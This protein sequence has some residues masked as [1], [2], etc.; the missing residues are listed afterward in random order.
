MVAFLDDDIIPAPGWVQALVDDVRP[1]DQKVFHMGYCPHA[2]SSI[3]TYLDRRNA[4]WYE[5]RIR[6]ISR[7][8]YEPRWQDFFCGN[9]AASRQELLELGGFDARFRI[10]EDDELGF[11]AFKNGWRI[12]FV[13]NA[14]A[15]HHFHR[16]HRAYG[17]QAF[18]AGRFDGLLVRLHPEMTPF[19]RIGTR[20]AAWKRAPG[21]I[22]K[23][24][25]VNSRRSVE[26]VERIAGV[27]EEL[28]MIPV[29]DVVYPLI[30]DGNYWRG[31]AA[32]RAA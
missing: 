20:R 8:G 1:D 29:L 12:R 27:G 23:A 28:N 17:R 15:E 31:V 10:S 11:R 21:W 32:A 3:R 18:M 26:I 9:F 19:V 13:P 30:W 24:V 4:A 22:W 25:A 6:E 2:P 7:P 14:R 5:S 16:D